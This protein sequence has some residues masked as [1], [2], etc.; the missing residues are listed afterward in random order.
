MSTAFPYGALR[1]KERVGDQIVLIYQPVF[2]QENFTEVKHLLNKSILA[3][4]GNLK[5]YVNLNINVQTNKVRIHK[6]LSQPLI[7]QY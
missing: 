7:K 4:T 2:Y 5:Y 1:Q 6:D 3:N